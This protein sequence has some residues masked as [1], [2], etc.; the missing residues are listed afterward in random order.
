MDNV[1]GITSWSRSCE[2][3]YPTVFTA[4]AEVKDWITNVTG[5]L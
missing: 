5:T 1:V 3:R 2:W 4:I